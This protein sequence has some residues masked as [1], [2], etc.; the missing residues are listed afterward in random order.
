MV[1]ETWYS[2]VLWWVSSSI[3]EHSVN[4]IGIR[5]SQRKYFCVFLRPLIFSDV[6]WVCCT[7]AVLAGVAGKTMVPNMW[8]VLPGDAS[9][10]ILSHQIAIIR[11]KHT[12][13]LSLTAHLPLSR[14]RRRM[15]RAKWLFIA[16][17][18]R[19]SGN[20]CRHPWLCNG[21]CTAHCRHGDTL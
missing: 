5:W 16:L 12:Y 18:Y 7:C 21:A 20:L 17:G 3:T 15:Y 13:L 14:T 2:W 8:S 6:W 19:R 9:S 1:Y 11:S 4:W 10:S